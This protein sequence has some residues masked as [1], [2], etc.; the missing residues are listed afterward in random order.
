MAQ[1][2]INA[3]HQVNLTL[4]PAFLNDEKKDKYTSA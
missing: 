2:L 4:L 3:Q 1:A